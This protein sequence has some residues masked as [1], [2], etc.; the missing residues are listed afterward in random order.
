VFYKTSSIYQRIGRLEKVLKIE[1]DGYSPIGLKVVE[2]I[3]KNPI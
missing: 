3:T 1:K 2:H